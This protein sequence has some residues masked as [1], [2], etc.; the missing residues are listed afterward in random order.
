MAFSQVIEDKNSP[1]GK[2]LVRLSG[3]TDA[4][5]AAAMAVAQ[6][7]K[8]T[9]DAALPLDGSKEMTGDLNIRKLLPVIVL[10]HNDIAREDDLASVHQSWFFMYDKDNKPLGGI[11]EYLSNEKH[12]IYLRVYR[13]TE[14]FAIS[15]LSI[16]Y[17]KEGAPYATSPHPRSDNYGTDIVTMKALKDYAPMKVA[18]TVNIHINTE[19]GSDTAG[20]LAGRGFSEDKPLKTL[21]AALGLTA[22]HIGTGQV[23]IILHSDVT[24]SELISFA[25][26]QCRVVTITSDTT[27]RKIRCTDS[28]A[29]LSIVAGRVVLENIELAGEASCARILSVSNNGYMS[30]RTG[31]VFSGA[32]NDS[33]VGAFTGGILEIAQAITGTIT[34]KKY[35][36]TNGGMIIGASKIPGTIDGTCDANS[37]AFG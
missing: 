10:T 27:L 13:Q 19:T 1:T 31:V 12:V 21:G 37:K 7:A 6:E 8:Q 22:G 25:C 26:A 4:G 5:S 35:L 20:L 11:A 9:A 33:I 36:C 28:L 2:S 16:V 17:E 15:D 34:G 23:N 29:Q 30:I 14:E 18:N 3:A 32:C 24:L